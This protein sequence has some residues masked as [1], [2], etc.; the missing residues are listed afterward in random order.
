MSK[1]LAKSPAVNSPCLSAS[2]TIVFTVLKYLGQVDDTVS[3]EIALLVV[4]VQ[5]CHKDGSRI[6]GITLVHQNVDL[7]AM[8]QE[9][10]A[11]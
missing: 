3:N 7:F 10:L 2:P 8:Q 6:F 11:R 5:T 9:P 4:L 1:T